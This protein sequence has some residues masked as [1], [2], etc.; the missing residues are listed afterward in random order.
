MPSEGIEEELH[1]QLSLL[2]RHYA[3]LSPSSPALIPPAAFPPPLVLSQPSTQ[4]WL[5]DNALGHDAAEEQEQE[6]GA[7]NWKRGFW[8]RILGGIDHGFTE[9]KDRGE[10]AA[11][12]DEVR[13]L[14]VRRL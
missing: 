1:D 14:W 4:Q 8:R 12:E 9:R 13:A 3:A 10:A 7:R 11:V 2:L 6:E 5:V